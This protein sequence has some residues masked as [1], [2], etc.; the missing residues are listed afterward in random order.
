VGR[1]RPTGENVGIDILTISDLETLKV[2]ADPLRLEI[3]ELLRVEPQTVKEV[4]EA[5]DIP[6][7]RLYYHFRTLEEHGLI[8]VSGTR[9]VSGIIEKHYSAAAQRLSV[10]RSLLSPGDGDAEDGLG[11]M[12]SVILDEARSEIR[13]SARA[14]L[15]DLAEEAQGESNLILGRRWMRISPERAHEFFKRLMDLQDEYESTPDEDAIA[16]EFLAG[17]YPTLRKA[18]EVEIVAFKPGATGAPEV[19]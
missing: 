15:I 8:R 3:F 1:G 6:P 19:S 17:L 5:L 13:R 18:Y 11:V 9:V 2:V 12:L 4:A 14:G 7:T 16:Y 10:D